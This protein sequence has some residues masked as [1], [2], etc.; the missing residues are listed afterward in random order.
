MN[1]LIRDAVNLRNDSTLRM[2]ARPEDAN[3]M[4]QAMFI[5]IVNAQRR[6]LGNPG[7]IT[8][9]TDGRVTTIKVR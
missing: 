8:L 3:V 1:N 9:S 7:S 5:A 2:G 4:V 6:A